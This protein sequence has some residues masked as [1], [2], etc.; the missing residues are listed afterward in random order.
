MAVTMKRI[1]S[2]ILALS[3]GVAPV[4]AS[5]V[6]QITL[7]QVS[8]SQAEEAERLL[9]QGRLQTQQSELS[10]AIDT[11]QRVLTI[12]QQLKDKPLESTA[13]NSIGGIYSRQGRYSKALEFYQQSLA[14][15]KEV[16]NRSNEGRSLNNIG[17]IYSRL[18]QYPKALEFYQQ[19]LAILKQISDRS[20][21]GIMLNNIGGIYDGLGQYP[22]A[23]EFYQQSLA[24]L[25]QIGDRSGEGTTLN[26]I[27][28][29]YRS[30]KQ[31]SKAL[32]IYKRAL[33]LRREIGDRSG[34][35]STLNNIGAVYND[36]SQYDEALKNYEQALVRRREIGDRGGEASTL[37]NIGAVYNAREDYAKSLAF[38]SQALP[39]FRAVGDRS[40]EA[41]ALNNLGQVYLAN[42]QLEQAL[43]SYSQALPL[44]RVVGDRS[45]EATGLS[46]I[47]QTYFKLDKTEEALKYF[48]QSL[49]IFRE[50]GNRSSEANVLNNIGRIHQ[51]IGHSEKALKYFYDALI[52]LKE[53]DKKPNKTTSSDD[54]QF[55][56]HQLKTLY[57]S[58]QTEIKI[59]ASK[60]Q[61]KENNIRN[62][63]DSD[64]IEKLKQ[65]LHDYSELWKITGEVINRLQEAS[66]NIN[67][68][69]ILL[70]KQQPLEAIKSFELA[71]DI[72]REQGDRYGESNTQVYIAEAYRSTNRLN[73][74]IS[75]LKDAVTITLRIRGGVTKEN[76]KRFSQLDSRRK[77]VVDLVTLLLTQNQ[78]DQAFEWFTLSGTAE[79]AD[80]T[81][82]INAKTGNDNVQQ[83]IEQWNLKNQQ[84]QSLRRQLNNNFSPEKSRQMRSLEESLFQ[85]AEELSQKFPE[86][87][88]L[89]EATPQQIS[90]L[91]ASIP[92]GTLVIQPVLLNSKLKGEDKIVFFILSK[93]GPV[94]VESVDTNTQELDILINQYLQQLQNRYDS[95]FTITQEKLYKLLFQP[96]EAKVSEF[97]PT[98]LSFILT[99]KLRHIPFETLYD[100]KTKQYLIQKYSINYLTRLSIHSLLAARTEKLKQPQQVLAFGNPIPTD[101][102]GLPGAET[103]VKN[104]AQVLLGSETFIGSQAT[105]DTFKVQAPRFSFLHLATHGC[106]QKGGCPKLGMEENT[107]LFAD[108]QFNIA[109]AALLGLQDTDLITLSAC[110]TALETNSNGEEIA[111]LAYLFER[112]G[113]KATIASLWN[114]EDTTTQ[115]IMVQFYENLKQGMSKGEALRQ[116]KLSQIDGHPFFWAPFVLIGDAR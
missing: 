95:E 92:Q 16:A 64:L 55:Q 78:Y 100:G 20:G 48:K 52:L 3:I 4:I 51:K 75:H 32:E 111:G 30:T 73:E 19:S 86:V 47:G 98:Q 46:S 80:Y 79:L 72:Y 102:L 9:K 109:D 13:L 45:G 93:E 77:I 23:L 60:T 65:S 58:D 99:G 7:G 54:S 94:T 34:E 106:F 89:F 104:I 74:A 108:K 71:Q 33:V 39:L 70:E 116:A 8:S 87:A 24:I 44:F 5:S 21:E 110:Q 82:L 81:R 1:L 2:S 37:N 90:Q 68:G 113:A 31:F 25:Q 53:I 59:K 38:Y 17:G 66:I 28:A 67:I 105:L 91:K 6:G 35:A 56:T 57:F 43:K 114:A 49:S 107:I 115:V 76:R 26:N 84:L 96:I 88:E 97:S 103:E 41:T 10:Q 18:G 27:G 101:R 36:L 14:I 15:S 85:D 83:A 40:G 62:N 12:S 69:Q 42:D 50:I 112:A 11:F 61:S 63:P 22:K 29:V